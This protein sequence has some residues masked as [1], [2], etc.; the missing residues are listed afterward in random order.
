MNVELVDLGCAAFAWKDEVDV[1][2]E[3]DPRVEWNPAEDEVKGGFEGVDDGENDPVH[4]PWCQLAWIGCAESLVGGEDW[5]EDCGDDAVS[6]KPNV[7]LLDNFELSHA[8]QLLPK[9]RLL[10]VKL[11][12]DFELLD[13]KG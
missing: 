13:K 11:L 12:S 6:C 3:T 7:N 2:A 1:C 5:E 10:Y 9:A 8:V 4:E